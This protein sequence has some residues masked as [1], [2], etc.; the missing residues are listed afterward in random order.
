MHLRHRGPV[1]DAALAL[2]GECHCERPVPA[3]TACGHRCAGSGVGPSCGCRTRPWSTTS[4]CWA[5]CGRSG[6]QYTHGTGDPQAVSTDGYT[7][8][9][10]YLAR[11]GADEIQLDLFGDY[12]SNVEL[13]PSFQ[14]YFRKHRPALLAAWG[15]NHP[16]FLSAGAE[17]FA[18]DNPTWEPAGGRCSEPTARPAALR[19]RW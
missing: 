13:Y 2:L 8:D 18:R 16:F 11:P 7:L 4:R 15:R 5:C 12:R 1:G 3:V 9:N 19:P 10:F 17:A 6:R 14:G